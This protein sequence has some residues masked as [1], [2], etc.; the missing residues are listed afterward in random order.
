[1][2][3]ADEPY[4]RV[5]KR[6]TP[7]WALVPWRTRNFFS[8]ELC[9]LVDRSGVLELGRAG[10]R[11][12][13]ALI[14]GATLADLPEIEGHIRVLCEDGCVR[15]N[16]T[17]LIIPNYLSAQECRQSDRLRQADSR[18]KRR[19]AALGAG[20]SGDTTPETSPP[21]TTR[22]QPSP[23]V[24]DCHSSLPSFLPSFPPTPRTAEAAEG[25][26]VPD[27][28]PASQPEQPATEPPPD[29]APA[30]TP[31][32]EK[33]SEQDDEQAYVDAY[34]EHFG[35]PHA[36]LTKRGRRTFR[37]LR[38]R[39][40]LAALIGSIPNLAKDELT[41]KWSLDQVCSQAGIDRGCRVPSTD[42]A[43]PERPASPS[44]PAP[45]PEVPRLSPSQAAQNLARL[46]S[47]G[48]LNAFP[49]A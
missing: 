8:A 3:W 2:N 18:G 48:V 14:P 6:I 33:H 43:E 31:A 30:T 46:R 13:V 5:Y 4:I 41:R 7:D 1:M 44:P 20:N 11:G 40:G 49:E 15:I 37:E 25:E 16:G 19:A 17:T 38:A 47:L 34:R 26:S 42:S 27:E 23:A 36:D 32:P 39:V 45:G 21:V 22:H 29:T 9:R 28:R 24:T 10:I 35:S 12:V